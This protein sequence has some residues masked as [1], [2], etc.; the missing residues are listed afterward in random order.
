MGFIDDDTLKSGKKLQG[1]PVLG[2][3]RDLPSLVAPHRIRGLIVSFHGQ[4]PA[5]LAAVQ[6]FC[7]RNDLFLKKFSI[8][9]EN[10][11]EA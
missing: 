7:R 9:I 11:D 1:Y 10:A 8:H 5:A 3:F 2:T 4:D 6:Q